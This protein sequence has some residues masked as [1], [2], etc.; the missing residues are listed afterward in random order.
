MI[1]LLI[2]RHGSGD[3]VYLIRFYYMPPGALEPSRRI[4]RARAKITLQ[5]RKDSVVP[6][7]KSV[8]LFQAEVSELFLRGR[9]TGRIGFAIEVCG[10]A[11]AGLS[12]CRS[13]EIE[14][15]LI[16]GQR[17]ASPVFGYFR[18]EAVFNGVPF[19]SASRIMSDGDF[20]AEGVAEL[21]LDFSFPGEETAVIA[22]A[23]V[24]KD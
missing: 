22:A 13:D 11:Q 21:R 24:G 5:M 23:S 12:F 4:D 15:S 6:V 17:L 19:G 3:E 8:M 18:E 9:Q 16:G 7:W 1:C 2:A 20:Q 10:D 14:D